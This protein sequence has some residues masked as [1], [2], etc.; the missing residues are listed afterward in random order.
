MELNDYVKTSFRRVELTLEVEHDVRLTALTDDVA[1]TI[2][3]STLCGTATKWA[4]SRAYASLEDLADQLIS[5]IRVE[6]ANVNLLTVCV[7]TKGPVFGKAIGLKRFWCRDV[8][9]TLLK[10]RPTS[11]YFLEDWTC[12]AIIGIHP[13]ERVNRQRLKLN[14]LV[15]RRFG[16]PIKSST[17]NF[18]AFSQMLYNVGGTA[19]ISY[20][21]VLTIALNTLHTHS[22]SVMT[23][24]LATSL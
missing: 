17:F 16:A 20:Y 18:R 22:T 15:E 9:S 5:A 8:S 14:I 10:D 13:H 19:N 11:T 7:S 12:D 23:L 3:Y 2:N 6:H 1:H 24:L 4:S 21:R